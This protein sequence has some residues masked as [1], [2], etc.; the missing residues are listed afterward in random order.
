VIDERGESPRPARVH[1]ATEGRRLAGVCAGLGRS[2]R[3]RVGRARAAFVVAALCGGLGVAI[4]LACWLIIPTSDASEERQ[5]PGSLVAVAWAS[6]GVL[7]LLLLG[8]LSA[9]ATVFGLGWLA[10]VAAA[11]TLAAAIMPR[12]RLGQMTALLAVA[13][14][15]LPAVAVALSSVRLTLQSGAS[16]IAPPS[17]AAVR[18]STYRSGLGT[19]LIDLRHTS[20]PASGTIPLQIEAGIKRTIVALPADRCVR[21]RVRYAVN[22]F[23]RQ[24]ASLLTGRW[25]AAD[26]GVDVFGS[27]H[28]SVASSAPDRVVTSAA[29][30]PGP[31]LLIDFH[32]QG[33]DL[34]VRDYPGSVSPDAE[35]NWPGFHVTPEPRPDLR[36]EPKRV[37][38]GMLRAWRARRRA[39]LASAREVNPLIPGP[40]ASPR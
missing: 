19:L 17:A 15:T 13:A 2:D 1:R 3:V 34:Y 32:S 26:Y 7:G 25:A 40:C 4:Y 21:V 30:R 20:L 6:A 8:A 14:M 22:P 5:S 28:P 35:P 18:G 27:F 12:I 29:A 23:A 9:A 38:P 33:G 37:I 24:L 10:V 16:V 39:E 11:A 36:G 31:T